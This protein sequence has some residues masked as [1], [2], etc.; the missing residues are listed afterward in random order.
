MSTACRQLAAG[1]DPRKRCEFLVKKKRVSVAAIDTGAPFVDFNK[2]VTQSA[3][4]IPEFGIASGTRRNKLLESREVD[5]YTLKILE[6]EHTYRRKVR[7]G[8]LS[9]TRFVRGMKQFSPPWLLDDFNTQTTSDAVRARNVR[10]SI[11]AI[12]SALVRKGFRTGTK[13]YNT[14]LV[15]ALIAWVV[16]AKRKGGLGIIPV[17]ISPL[18]V[19]QERT[20]LQILAS[21]NPRVHCTE[22]SYL[23]YEV[24]RIAGLKPAFLLVHRKYDGTESLTHYCVSVRLDP[25]RSKTLTVIDPT[26][27]Q[28]NKWVGTPHKAVVRLPRATMLGVYHNNRASSKFNHAKPYKMN[29]PTKHFIGASLKR[30]MAYGNTYPMFSYNRAVYFMRAMGN[31]KSAKTYLEAS[32][33][34]FPNFG[35]ALGLK[36]TWFPSHGSAG[37]PF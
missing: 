31:A 36:K 3:T 24:F 12:K 17:N 19:K 37:L 23:L 34:A 21:T 13:I 16:R 28:R 20:V 35:N 15:H 27:P 10:K 9:L 6:K 22:V 11:D 30:A 18:L 7:Y 29:A 8:R 2:V 5:E 26:H 14:K 33:K 32:L 1:S 4:H 25:A